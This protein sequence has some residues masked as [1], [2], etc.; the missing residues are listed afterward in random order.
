M[1][2]NNPQLNSWKFSKNQKWCYIQKILDILTPNQAIQFQAIW[3]RENGINVEQWISRNNKNK[4]PCFGQA[5]AVFGFLFK[6][7][8]FPFS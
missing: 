5:V 7:Y 4:A 3:S 1:T 8:F 2:G 6:S